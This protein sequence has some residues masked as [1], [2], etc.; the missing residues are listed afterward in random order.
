VF[1]FD[2][3]R[4][5]SQNHITFGTFESLALG[6]VELRIQ[7]WAIS[8]FYGVYPQP[9]GT[10]IKNHFKWRLLAANKDLGKYLDV[11]IILQV[12]G[13]KALFIKL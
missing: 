3:S 5:I 2:H 7:F 1:S 12:F 4:P 8:T 9:I 11:L 13:D 10:C 6:K